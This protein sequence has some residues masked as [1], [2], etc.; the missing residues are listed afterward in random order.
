MWYEDKPNL[1]LNESV[2]GASVQGALDCYLM[3]HGRAPLFVLAHPS[4]LT[5]P[6]VVGKVEVRPSVV[7]KQPRYLLLV[8]E[9]G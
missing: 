2:Q 9:A 5:A 3:R 7:I 6:R 4:A 1:S 8:M